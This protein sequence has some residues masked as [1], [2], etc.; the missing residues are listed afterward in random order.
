MKIS[1]LDVSLVHMFS[2][3]Q[4]VKT[5]LWKVLCGEL[6]PPLW[7]KLE[8]NEQNRFMVITDFI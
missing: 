6:C 3:A 7:T 8:I 1:R 4:P 2:A 5:V